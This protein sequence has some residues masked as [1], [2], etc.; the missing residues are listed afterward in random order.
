MLSVHYRH[1]INFSKDLVDAAATGLERI[2]TAYN[3]I[4]HRL[5][6]TAS[7]G[8]HSEQWLEKIEEQKAHF[9]EAMDDDFNTANGISVLFELARIANIYLNETNTNDK[10][11][12]YFMETFEALGDV[13]GIEFAKEEELL[14]EEIEALLQERVEARKNRDFARSDEIRD[15]LQ[16]QGIILEDTRQGTRWKRG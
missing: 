8:D 6:A 14:D 10:V 4:K 2:L 15:H 5:T 9:E 11:L 1:P 7:L 12:S 3:N 13:L 16:A